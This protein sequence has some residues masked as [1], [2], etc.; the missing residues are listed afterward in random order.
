MRMCIK[1]NI[2]AKD[3]DDY[4]Q[5]M[6]IA[7]IFSGSAEYVLQQNVLPSFKWCETSSLLGAAYWHGCD[8]EGGNK[9]ICLAANV[10]ESSCSFN[11]W[12]SFLQKLLG[13]LL[14]GHSDETQLGFD[15]CIPWWKRRN[16]PEYYLIQFLAFSCF[17]TTLRNVSGT[18]TPR[19]M[20]FFPVCTEPFFLAQRIN[21]SRRKTFGAKARAFSRKKAL[22]IMSAG[23]IF[24]K[25]GKFRIQIW[26]SFT[27]LLSANVSV[28]K[29]SQ[30]DPLLTRQNIFQAGILNLVT[31]DLI[32]CVFSAFHSTSFSL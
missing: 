23:N 8:L 14:S 9:N 4:A 32:H 2:R 30:S 16:K 26:L 12:I 24:S 20:Y 11:V 17:S 7:T 18:S 27:D 25:R 31:S 13:N 22:D 15:L 21:L 19:E 10:A 28:E 3:P 29:M 6:A 1:Y 5:P